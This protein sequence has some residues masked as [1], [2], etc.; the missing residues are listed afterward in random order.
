MAW[1]DYAIT[2]DSISLDDY[3]D[4]V[5]VVTEG[6]ANREDSNF[7]VPGTDG[8]VS[9]PNKLWDSG[10][11]ILVTFLRYSDADGLVTHVDGASGHVYENLS[12][13]KRI[14]GKNGQVVL[15]RTAPHHGIVTMNVELIQG[16][17]EASFPAHLVWVLKAPVP[18]W[19]G[20]TDVVISASGAHT[21]EGDAPIGDMVVEFAGNGKAQIDDEWIEMLGAATGAIVNVGH[22]R[23]IIDS[24]SGG[25]PLDRYFFNYSDR[26]LRLEG[27][28]QS[29]VTITG[30]VTITYRSKWHGGG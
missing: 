23:S 20:D 4:R 24:G 12:A 5:V 1:T 30:T 15:Q 3:C 6:M 9:F 14:F 27:G 13:L 10:N 19:S 8:E 2:A 16:P 17:S 28:R 18:F 7:K 29:T 25:G 26:W 11:V 22:P 21:P